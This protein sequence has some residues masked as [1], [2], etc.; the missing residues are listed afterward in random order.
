[1]LAN[2]SLAQLSSERLHLAAD[3][4]K[5]RNPQ[6][7]IRQ[8]SGS[9]EEESGEGLRIEGSRTSHEVLQSQLT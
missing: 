8:G 5:C 6:P 3:G 4:D 1:M 9:I 2:R 7:S